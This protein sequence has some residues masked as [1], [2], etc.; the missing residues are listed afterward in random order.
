MAEEVDPDPVPLQTK[1]QKKPTTKKPMNQAPYKSQAVELK[2]TTQKVD[3]SSQIQK[4]PT[5][6]QPEPTTTQKVDASSQT[7]TQPNRANLALMSPVEK[8]IY[9]CRVHNKC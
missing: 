2:P 8:R 6:V 4:S 5:Q 3:T 7:T 1:Q 9:M